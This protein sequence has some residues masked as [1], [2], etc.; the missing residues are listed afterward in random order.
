MFIRRLMLLL[1]RRH[2]I[3]GHFFRETLSIPTQRIIEDPNDRKSHDSYFIQLAD[4]NAYACHRSQHIDPQPS[5]PPGL[6]DEIA[7]LH[8]TSVNQ[9]RGGPPAIVRY[10]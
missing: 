9:L 4:W 3:P 7:N 5:V 8:R 2:L 6:W 1:R 10:P